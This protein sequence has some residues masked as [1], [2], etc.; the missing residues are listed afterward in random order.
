MKK[1]DIKSVTERFCPNAERNV[2]LEISI[3]ENGEVT[4]NCLFRHF[5]DGYPYKEK[6]C[7][8]HFNTE[9]PAS[10]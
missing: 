9:P 1:Q 5:C 10:V 7:V 3:G 8:L 2:A 6:G 4:E